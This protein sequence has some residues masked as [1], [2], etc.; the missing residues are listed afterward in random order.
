MRRAAL[1]L[2]LLAAPPAVRS[3]QLEASYGREHVSGGRADWQSAAAAA[4]WTREDRARLE[5]GLSG[6]E[7]F[8]RRDASAL[9]GAGAPFGTGW[10]LAAEA[11]A[12]PSH[13]VVPA[14]AL[15]LQLGRELG[16]GAVAAAGFRWSRFLVAAGTVDVGLGSL[17]VERYWG[18]WRA[19]ATGYAATVRGAWS[20]SARL[21]LD[22]FYGEEGRVGVAAAAG[23]E[24][25]VAETR[26]LLS[27][28][29][30]AAGLA[31]LHGLG[32][33]WALVWEAGF[34]RQGDLYTRSG[35]R[36]GI[37]RRF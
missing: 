6:V 2:L 11:A 33:G 13:E 37:R 19:G 14:L 23:R 4:S 17:G 18:A 15:G 29:V 10:S 7:R 1:A 26:E 21:A 16:G 22:W 31:G 25:E 9:A 20:A 32:A 34:Q 3:L 12:S 28:R 8:G 27:S 36:L 30:V 5:L 24:L 35:G